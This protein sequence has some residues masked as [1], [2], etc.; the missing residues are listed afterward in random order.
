MQIMAN[1]QT[2]AV[3]TLMCWHGRKL[4]PLEETSELCILFDGLTRIYLKKHPEAVRPIQTPN[5]HKT[6]VLA[7]WTN[8]FNA[9]C[10]ICS[11][12]QPFFIEFKNLQTTLAETDLILLDFCATHAVAHHEFR[13]DVFAAFD[14]NRLKDQALK[15][16]IDT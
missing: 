1:F 11:S 7:Y 8:K 12:A 10:L 16:K 2:Y 4:L 14:L 5:I 13:A 3:C 6:L 15:K 9:F